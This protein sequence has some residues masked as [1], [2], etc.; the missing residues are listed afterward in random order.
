MEWT[1]AG[2][3]R[4]NQMSD[5]YIIFQNMQITHTACWSTM[6]VHLLFPMKYILCG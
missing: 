5:L 2:V 3:L 4:T 1:C 6:Y